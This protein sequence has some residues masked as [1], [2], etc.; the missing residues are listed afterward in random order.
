MT[1]NYIK[2]KILSEDNL[3]KIRKL[4]DECKWRDGLYTA[5]GFNHQRKNNLEAEPTE[6]SEKIN[7]IIMSSLDGDYSFF[8]YCVPDTSNQVIISKTE[9]GGFYNVHHDN[10]SNG[11]YSTTVFLSDP[12][13]YEGGELCLYID[14][15]EKVFKPVAGTAITYHTGLMHKVNK[16]I[17]GTRYAAVFWTKS[18]FD[19]TFIREIYSE[20][21]SVVVKMPINNHDNFGDALEDSRFILE[22]VLNKLT[23]KF[24]KQ[25]K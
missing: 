9:S 19:D 24:L 14:G 20:I 21:E 4:I 15:R 6:S 10:A 11:H 13:E 8:Q 2:R 16:V 5:P 23:R 22:E 17:S 25:L 12:S 7:E 3:I 18:K 1:K